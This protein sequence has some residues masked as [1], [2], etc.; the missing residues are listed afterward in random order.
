VARSLERSHDDELGVLYEF[1]VP[2]VAHLCSVGKKASST[3][4]TFVREVRTTLAEE[5]EIREAEE[6]ENA[7]D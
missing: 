3:R 6:R 5:Q 1:R 2:T 7:S 4:R